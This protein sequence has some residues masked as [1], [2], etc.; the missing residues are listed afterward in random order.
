MNIRHRIAMCRSD[1]FTHFPKMRG[2][3][4]PSRRAFTAL[5]ER[6]AAIHTPAK[7]SPAEKYYGSMG[8]QAIG[9]PL[10]DT[11][12]IHPKTASQEITDDEWLS[13]HS[14]HPP[15]SDAHRNFRRHMKQGSTPQQQPMTLRDVADFFKRKF[16]GTPSKPSPQDLSN[17]TTR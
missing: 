3:S 8:A 13:A 11:A 10:W 14:A 4:I 6:R 7:L 2:I 16:G 1:L 12:N 17:D 5:A 15:P 9:D